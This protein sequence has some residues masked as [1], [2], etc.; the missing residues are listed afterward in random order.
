M[1]YLLLLYVG[2]ADMAAASKDDSRKM[3]AA[4]GA[5]AEAMVQ[6]GV[7]VGAN[8]LRPTETA[9]TVRSP[10][11]KTQVLD[12]PYAETKEQLGGYFMIEVPDLDTALSWAERCPTVGHGVV[13][14]RPVWPASDYD[15]DR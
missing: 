14:V 7:M 5:Y 11:G 1:Q 8:R 9:T 15:P 2:E 6:A 4:Y 3:T 13:E 12:G 10:G